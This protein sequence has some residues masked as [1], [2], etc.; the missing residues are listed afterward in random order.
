MYF[1]EY[2]LPLWYFSFS[3]IFLLFS[4][5]YFFYRILVARKFKYKKRIEKRD[6]RYLYLLVLGLINITISLQNITT[7]LQNKNT[8]NIFL[9]IILIGVGFY[10]YDYNF[11]LNEGL[12]IK[13]R[14]IPW[15]KINSMD[16]KKNNKAIVLSYFKN[17]NGSKI[18][19]VTFN[20][21]Y[22]SKLE[23][24]NMQKDKV[25][26][27][28]IDKVDKIYP[29][30]NV[31][32]RLDLASIVFLMIFIY[33]FYNLLQPKALGGIIDKTFNHTE[34]SSVVVLYQGEFENQGLPY[35]MSTTSKEER[36]KEIKNF[37]N[38]FYIRKIPYQD[39]GYTSI[40]GYPYSIKLYELTGDKVEI[41]ISKSEPILEI[42]TNNK[43]RSYFIESGYENLK[44]IN[45][46]GESID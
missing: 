40:K 42:K 12:F 30:K 5:Y 32:I 44:F 24:E 39:L 8:I 33:G 35:D 37:L 10:L 1:K 43:K 6:F 9:A 27:T 34:T 36:I 46:F 22:N 17:N 15:N 18:S 19:K 20:I 21:R 28:N 29:D 41:F 31:K 13:G 2:V 38:S 11:I 26:N 16:Y 3:I 45:K 25:D 7:S 14:F 23:L 4:I